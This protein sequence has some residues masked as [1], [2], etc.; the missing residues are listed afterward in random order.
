MSHLVSYETS[1]SNRFETRKT[2]LGYIVS[3]YVY[4]FY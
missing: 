3:M 2:G 1:T 4:L